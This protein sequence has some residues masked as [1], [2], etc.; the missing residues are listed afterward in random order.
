MQRLA[1]VAQNGLTFSREEFDRLRYE[2][3]ARIAAEM[4]TY[5]DGPL[6]PVASLFRSPAGYATPKVI[7]R[8][9]VFDR[10]ERILMVRESA[11][12]LWTLPGGWIDVGE[13]PASSARRE[14]EEETGYRVRVVK[15]AGI[16]DKLRH[17]HPPAPH[18]SYLIFFL[19]ELEGGDPAASYETSEVGWFEEDRLPELS[20]GRA[21]EGQIRRMFEHHRSPGLPA[22]FDPPSG[23]NG[24]GWETDADHD[25]R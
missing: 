2:D 13:S 16:Y 9:A 25:P 6:E 20:T 17:P 24:V 8:A 10:D 14:V 1:A 18:H 21:T 15:L 12:G 3:V 5:P 4:A 11:D 7:C 19:C 22:D 23:V